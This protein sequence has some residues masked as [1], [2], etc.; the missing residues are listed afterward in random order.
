MARRRSTVERPPELTFH[1][2]RFLRVGFAVDRRLLD[3]P[4]LLRGPWQAHRDEVLAEWIEDRPGTRPWAWWEFD[5]P[6]AREVVGVRHPP[7]ARFGKSFALHVATIDWVRLESEPA[8]LRRHGLL[9][10]AEAARLEPEMYGAVWIPKSA[11]K[12]RWW[13]PHPWEERA[14]NEPAEVAAC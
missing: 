10:D 7:H 14:V 9:T 2:R 6:E 11:R 12:G 13:D 8:Y 4:D 1:E 5:A 3:D